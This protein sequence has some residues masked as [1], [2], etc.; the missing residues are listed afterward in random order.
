MEEKSKL[1]QAVTT[2]QLSAEDA[3]SLAT[4]A[5]KQR[6]KAQLKLAYQKLLGEDHP[7]KDVIISKWIL[8]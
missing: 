8:Q 3:K 2:D 1:L 7:I 5:T 4:P 6:I